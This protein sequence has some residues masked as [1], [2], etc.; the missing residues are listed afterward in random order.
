MYKIKIKLICE[1]IWTCFWVL[2]LSPCL[3]SVT[4][5]KG[6]LIFLFNSLNFSNCVLL[7][8]VK[9]RRNS[10]IQMRAKFIAKVFVRNVH[11]R[12]CLD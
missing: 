9:T 5:L 7:G 2:V 12:A 8:L 4:V 11:N 10:Q 3:P 1:C 6:K